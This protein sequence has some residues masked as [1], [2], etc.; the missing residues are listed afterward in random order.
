MRSQID[1]LMRLTGLALLAMVWIG[2]GMESAHA[3]GGGFTGI[4][5]MTISMTADTTT[6]PIN[7]FNVTPN[8]G[9]PYTNTVSVKVT[10]NGSVLATPVNV[11]IVSGLSSGALYYL[12]GDS[13]HE[14]CPTGATCPPTAIWPSA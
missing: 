10:R 11:A 9:G 13:D 3:G 4:S 1:K 12:D 6:L 2:W 8:I 14:V 7:I 5:P